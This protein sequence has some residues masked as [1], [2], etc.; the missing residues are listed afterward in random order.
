MLC[1]LETI[2]YIFQSSEMV[3]IDI[4]FLNCVEFVTKK[5]F[6]FCREERIFEKNLEVMHKGE[7]TEVTIGLRGRLTF[8]CFMDLLMAGGIASLE[9]SLRQVISGSFS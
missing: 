9:Y 8:C 7:S 4:S 2:P 3:I 1:Q 5:P 6:W